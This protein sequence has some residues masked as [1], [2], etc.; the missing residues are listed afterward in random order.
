MITHFANVPIFNRTV[1][2]V[3]DCDG[4]DAEEVIY[5]LR[6][7]RTQVTLTYS[8]DGCVRDSGGDVF[9]WVKDLKKASVVAHELVH[10]ACSI[11]ELCGIPQCRE[12]E[13]VMCYLV[14]WLKIAV[15]DKV[16]QKLEKKL[17]KK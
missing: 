15:Q 11:M 1:F 4:Q 16:Y 14:G 8:A 17:E 10:A 9:V 7:K 12:T 13:E 5:R 3:G 6:R 2:F